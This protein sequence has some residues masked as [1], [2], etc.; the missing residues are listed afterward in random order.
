M[1]YAILVWEYHNL[2]RNNPLFPDGI[3]EEDDDEFHGASEELTRWRVYWLWVPTLCDICGTTVDVSMHII[4]AIIG[5]FLVLFAQT[6]TA[7][8]LVIEEKIMSK[9]RVETLRA[10]GLEEI[11]R[12]LTVVVRSIILSS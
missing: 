7:S 1:V 11:F 9:Y 12:L 5:F 6:F 2:K 4:E 8:Q 3:I 10:V